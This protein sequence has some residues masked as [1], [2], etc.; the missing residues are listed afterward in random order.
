MSNYIESLSQLTDRHK[1]LPP[2]VRKELEWILYSVNA[3]APRT[4]NVTRVRVKTVSGAGDDATVTGNDDYSFHI[5]LDLHD[6]EYSSVGLHQFLSLANA[7]MTLQT[8]WSLWLN[9]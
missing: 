4:P 7:R 5:F 6:T 2:E 8:L 9:S 3:L 1:L